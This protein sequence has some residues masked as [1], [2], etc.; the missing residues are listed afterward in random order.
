MDKVKN[1]IINVFNN[2]KTFILNHYESYKNRRY[3]KKQ[4]K[5]IIINMKEYD[6]KDINSKY[7]IILN[8]LRKDIPKL[9]DEY[10]DNDGYTDEGRPI[11]RSF[12][13]CPV[14]YKSLYLQDNYCSKCGQKICY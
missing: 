11:I 10:E 13:V 12:R 2:I 7:I 4:I 14:C 6:S 1:Y 9:A 8:S 5:D 3:L